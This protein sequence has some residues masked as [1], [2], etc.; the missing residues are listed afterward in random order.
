MLKRSVE[1]SSDKT[2]EE[3][4]DFNEGIGE[5]NQIEM[6]EKRAHKMTLSQSEP[7]IFFKRS[8]TIQVEHDKI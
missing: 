4:S 5:I 6:I 3:E 2:S 7:R 1:Q 8:S